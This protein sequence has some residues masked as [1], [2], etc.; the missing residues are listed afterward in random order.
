MLKFILL[1]FLF[2]VMFPPIYFAIVAAKDSMGNVTAMEPECCWEPDSREG[3]LSHTS[4]KNDDVEDQRE[5]VYPPD[6]ELC[7]SPC[8]K[9]I[10]SQN[11]SEDDFTPDD[12]DVITDE[13]YLVFVREQNDAEK[14]NEVTRDAENQYL[15]A[16][17]AY[18]CR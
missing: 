9:R 15:K 16:D 11:L 1:I 18:P 10:K 8:A 5:S 3:D 14:E 12:A 4:P 7:E 2:P 6:E 17:R 13:E